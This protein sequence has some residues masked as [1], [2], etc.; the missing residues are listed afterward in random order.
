MLNY[1]QNQ[2]KRYVINNHYTSIKPWQQ[3]IADRVVNNPYPF[4]LNHDEL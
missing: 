1:L 3:V 4:L 2:E